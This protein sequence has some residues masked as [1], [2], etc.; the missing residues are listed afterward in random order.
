MVR[1]TRSQRVGKA[2][3]MI[4][5]IICLIFDHW[6]PNLLILLPSAAEL[7]EAKERRARKASRLREKEL[8]QSQAFLLQLTF[9]PQVLSNRDRKLTHGIQGT[10]QWRNSHSGR[11]CLVMGAMALA[12]VLGLVAGTQVAVKKTV[13]VPHQLD[14]KWVIWEE[15]TSAE[16]M[17]P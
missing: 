7:G 13:W 15:G 11:I 14:T 12:E 10:R 9:Q 16:K 6:L 4:V 1:E 3:I 5:P 8:S 17:P 2:W